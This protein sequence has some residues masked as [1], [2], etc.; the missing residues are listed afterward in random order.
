M[1]KTLKTVAFVIMIAVFVWAGYYLFV[2]KE[3]KNETEVI[4]AEENKD[5]PK[6]EVK[7]AALPVTVLRIKKGD[8]PLRLPISATADVWDK[9][10]LKAEVTGVVQKINASIGDTVPKGKELIKLDDSE[11]RLEVDRAEATKLQTFSEYLTEESVKYQEDD[12]S[13]GEKDQEKMKNLE[14]EYQAAL[15]KYKKG[16][17]SEDE[18]DKI[19]DEYLKAKVYS[20]AYR[21]EIRKAQEG[22][23]D[24]SI[25]VKQA[26]LNLQRTSIQSPFP[27][28]ISDIMV[29]KGEKLTVGQDI[30][31]I[32]NLQSI[33][34]KGYALES[35]VKNLKTGI[36]V[37]IKFESF[38]DKYFYGKIESI[39][40]EI[41]PTNKTISIYAD[42]EN[43]N[44]MILPGMH[45]ELDVEYKVYKDVF[46][47]PRNA[48]I[49]RDRPLIF[50][51]D[52]KEK[53]ALWE[54]VETG[55]KNDEDWII[56][57]GLNNGIKEGDLVVVS[58]NM[59]L[60][61]QSRVQILEIIDQK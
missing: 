53:M 20:G 45:A 55:E 15:E 6:E 18:M 50:I 41:D 58:G 31:K 32:V 8:M 37:R 16:L 12:E 14:T 25:R 29:S 61:H 4:K 59:T 42:V 56:N 30:L 26:K 49:V 52:E 24:A 60:A 54:Y 21:E 27:G 11:I 3:A 28:T 19:G 38:P 39:S 57:K 22:F 7:E 47:V 51:V 43:K 2:Q 10:T 46:R 17:I 40:P 1:N 44:N 13:T 5:S 34:L 33:Y 23:A 36:S 48:V 35:E 9:A